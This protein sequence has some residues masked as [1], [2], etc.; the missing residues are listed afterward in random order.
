[1][2]YGSRPEADDETLLSLPG[3]AQ[4]SRPTVVPPVSYGV[5]AA[6]AATTTSGSTCYTLP[7]DSGGG[8]Y[9]GQSEN[10]HSCT[11]TV[12]SADLRRERTRGFPAWLR[13]TIHASRFVAAV[14]LL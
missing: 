12:A 2:G 3:P 5:S 9:T 7:G 13:P 4:D 14:L 11:A 10:G 8:C 6:T 1:M